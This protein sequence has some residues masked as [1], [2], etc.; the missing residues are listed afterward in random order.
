MKKS[1]GQNLPEIIEYVDQLIQPED[2]C[3]SEIRDRAEENKIRPI[4]VAKFDGR[5]IEVIARATGAKK[6]VELGTLA[7]YSTVC[8]A[9]ALPKDGKIWTFEYVPRHAECARESFRKSGFENQ[10][11]IIIG[12]A[13]ESLP[14]INHLGPFDLV[15]IDADKINYANYLDW[16]AENLRVGGV[17]LADNTFAW[18]MIT[19]K[20][21]ESDN[22]MVDVQA[23]QKFNDKI[24]N[25]PRFRTTMLP[26][27][28]GLT[29]AVKLK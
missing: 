23:L 20:D 1:Y 22:E 24:A 12:S 15:F 25:S 27:G 9:R 19:Q 14:K 5:H 26:T 17:I 11:E 18:D 21:F 13:L 3:L 6:I 28:E 10:I 16:A 4:H 8:L 29:L 7:G 2:S